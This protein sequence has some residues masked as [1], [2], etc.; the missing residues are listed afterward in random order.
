MSSETHKKGKFCNNI[1]AHSID[2]PR[3]NSN[4]TNK[5][6]EEEEK[7][8]ISVDCWVDLLP[9]VN[10]LLGCKFEKYVKIGLNCLQGVIKS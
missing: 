8:Y 5:N 3:K 6:M 2:L 4:F 9:L 10:S 7:Q 1:E